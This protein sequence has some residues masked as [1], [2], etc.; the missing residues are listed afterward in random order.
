MKAQ[1]YSAAAV[2]DHPEGSIRS[3]LLQAPAGG[4]PPP[5]PAFG[6]LICYFDAAGFRG[7]RVR[8]QATV[9][10]APE[11]AGKTPGATASGATT[12]A[13][14]TPRPRSEL[15]IRIELPGAKAGP[16]Y[17]MDDWQI[18]STA[19]GR[20]EVVGDV[21]TDAA[22]IRL[23]LALYGRGRAWI[24]AA[25][26]Q[27]V[28]KTTVAAATPRPLDPRG[29]DNLMA[30][31]RLVGLVRYF[32]P[33]DQAAAADWSGFV[34]A[35]VLQVEGARGPEELA[36]TLT[37]LFL[38][39]APTVRVFPS[40]H[41]APPAAE[42]L[43]PPAGNTNAH[44]VAWRHY[45]LGLGTTRGDLYKSERIDD[46]SPRAS[47]SA[48]PNPPLPAPGKPFAADLGAGVSALVPLAVYADEHGTLPAVPAGVQPAT[49]GTAEGFVPS[50][51]DRTTRLADVILAWNV[52]QYFYPYFDV[53]NTEWPAELRRALRSAA[54]DRDDK[55]FRETL[56]RLTAALHDG[57]AVVTSES[58]E[59][60]VAPPLLWD[61]VENRL[62]I[63]QVDREHA[64]GVEP[65][66][67]VVAIDGRRIAEALA[68]KEELISAATPQWR[69][70]RA[71]REL[72]AGP[73]G[74]VELRV[75]R[76]SGG[77]AT[78]T[79]T[80][81]LPLAGAG[82]IEEP[83]PAKIADV[84]P[85]I[86][87]VDLSRV[88][89]AGFESALPRMTKARG[90]IFDLRGYPD[91]PQDFLQHLSGKVLFSANFRVP[92]LTRPDRQQIAFDEGHW[93][94]EP[95]AP[96][97]TAKRAFLIDSRAVSAAE[98]YLGIIEYYHLAELVGTPTA[99]TNGD[100]ISFGL[101]GGYRI[102][103]T[104]IQVLKQDGSRHHGVGILP[105]IPVAPTIQ[106]I[107]AGRD[108]VLERA[109]VAVSQ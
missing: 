70:R 109:I 30:F 26:F 75:Q 60:R 59:R 44:V 94:L 96:L 82:A 13:D 67:V 85:G 45:G 91:L 25:S 8:F 39:L 78:V 53:V 14:G 5:A 24:S 27:T 19:W 21:P 81:S 73:P 66:D 101:P 20:Y 63:T 88:D 1:G 2:A 97:L 47:S 12:A 10:V 48:P 36:H 65:G 49:L 68:A 54:T 56:Q 4:P 106:G 74:S 103:W 16:I 41:P 11:E 92:I 17:G 93:T 37:T 86:L 33:S 3:A 9:K 34:R 18:T 90:L 64:A 77:E 35:G 108:E 15:A 22:A 83:R 102:S 51:N 89:E 23:V 99:G 7:Q 42:L 28:E 50:G 6:F 84:A 72:L 40:N 69:R 43:A 46:R 95:V 31:A 80:R 100:A 57:H 104:G 62:V 32:H 98:S 52:Y 76:P 38:P 61:W 87:Y 79:L 71:L 105:T 58:P 55:T 29:L 107:A